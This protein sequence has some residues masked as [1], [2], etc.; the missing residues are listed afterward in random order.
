M[1]AHVDNYINLINMIG[2]MQYVYIGSLQPKQKK[3]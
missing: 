1:N 3:K 2:T